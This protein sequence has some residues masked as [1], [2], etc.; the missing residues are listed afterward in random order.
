MATVRN[1]VMVSDKFEIVGICR[2]L[3]V[4]IIHRNGPT[5]ILPV[6]RQYYSIFWWYRVPFLAR[7]QVLL[8][9][10]S[11]FSMPGNL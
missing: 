8:I 9:S 5:G 1:F 10:G 6:T 7:T 11:S 4:E 3:L 2:G